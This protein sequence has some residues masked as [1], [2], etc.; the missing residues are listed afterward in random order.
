MSNPAAVTTDPLY[1]DLLIVKVFSVCGVERIVA[2]FSTTRTA[3]LIEKVGKQLLR[4]KT[5]VMLLETAENKK[6]FFGR[7]DGISSPKKSP[8]SLTLFSYIEFLL[9]SAFFKNLLDL[10]RDSTAAG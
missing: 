10:L 4:K 7:E 8:S 1:R 5:L 9:S 3:L 6:G 2:D